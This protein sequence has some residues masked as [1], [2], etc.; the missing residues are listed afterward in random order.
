MP[1]GNVYITVAKL[2]GLNPCLSLFWEEM[3]ALCGM[4]GAVQTFPRPW[5]QRGHGKIV[6]KT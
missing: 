6:T 4:A 2:A 1:T 5:E 3:F